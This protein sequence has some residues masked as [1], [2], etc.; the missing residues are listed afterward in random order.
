MVIWYMHVSQMTIKMMKQKGISVIKSF[1]GGHKVV[2]LMTYRLYH[3][4]GVRERI[5]LMKW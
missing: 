3:P 2:T 5:S 1:L 4:V